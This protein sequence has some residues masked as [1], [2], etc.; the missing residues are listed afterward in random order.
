ML[1]SLHYLYLLDHQSFTNEMLFIKNNYT[2]STLNDTIEN[3]EKSITLFFLWIA[4]C[5]F[6]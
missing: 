6:C 1:P 5:V 2:F 4:M 3:Y